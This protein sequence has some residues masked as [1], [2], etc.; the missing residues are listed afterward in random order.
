MQ[1]NSQRIDYLRR[2]IRMEKTIIL[3]SHYF[4]SIA[5]FEILVNNQSIVIDYGEHYL[6]Q[7]YRNRCLIYTSNGSLALSVPVIRKNKTLVKDVL[8]ELN[9]N[10]K[11]THWKAI[12]SAYNSSPFFEFYEHDLKTVFFKEHQ[13][14]PELNNELLKHICSEIGIITTINT[15]MVYINIDETNL[16]YRNLIDAKKSYVQADSYPRYI[17]TFE[18]KH[19]FIRNLSILDL[20][21][22]E[23]PET[24]NYMKAL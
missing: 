1:N 24:L 21:F 5:Y 16:D 11:K 15:S 6:K 14:L 2:Y 19:G 3:S 13:T 12:S 17:Q 9:S 7:S 8:L 23:G 18:E 22:H 10:W 20:L 4:P